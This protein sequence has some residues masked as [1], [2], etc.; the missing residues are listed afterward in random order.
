[1]LFRLPAVAALVL[2]AGASGAR[3]QVLRDLP[4]VELEY[5]IR[6]EGASEPAGT[7]SVSFRPVDTRRGRRLEVLSR[8]D[9]TVGADAPVEYH[10]TVA[11]TCDGKGVE[12]FETERR[13][14]A[15]DQRYLG[16]RTA[17]GYAITATVGGEVSQKTETGEV[18]LSNLGLFA[19]GFLETRLD[20]DEL[21]V[22]YPLLFPALGRHYPRQKVRVGSVSLAGPDGPL[23][24]IHTRMRKLGG[25]KDQLWHLD[26]EHQVLVRMV[27]TADHG[28]V[29]YSLVRLNGR[30]V[31]A[32]PGTI[33][34]AFPQ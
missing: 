9:F 22:D 6:M 18:Q 4:P 15:S 16:I 29:V 34:A 3:S 27:E 25:S 32:W 20:D 33:A 13:F 5:E 14:G 19:G 7:A 30:D 21:I 8:V 28:V 17:Q 11:L 31:S 26:D 2:L 1:L 24:V 10:E 23:D 12:K